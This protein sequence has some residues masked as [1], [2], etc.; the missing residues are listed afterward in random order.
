MHHLKC[1][2]HHH[3]RGCLNNFVVT[4]KVLLLV[5][6]KTM[7]YRWDKDNIEQNTVSAFVGDGGSAFDDNVTNKKWDQLG[8]EVKLYHQSVVSLVVLSAASTFGHA[9]WIAKQYQK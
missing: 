4:L 3:L 1:V 6:A 2:N 9:Y 8:Q 7:K 5:R